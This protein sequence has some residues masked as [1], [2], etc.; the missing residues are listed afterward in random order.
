MLS[1]PRA[2]ALCVDDD[3]HAI[4]VLQERGERSRDRGPS[5]VVDSRKTFRLV[6]AGAMFV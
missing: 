4:E 5:P 3:E 6:T 1:D 2:R